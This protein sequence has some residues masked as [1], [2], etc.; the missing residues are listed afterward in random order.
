MKKEMCKRIAGLSRKLAFILAAAMLLPA[1]AT[2]CE[3][4]RQI[5]ERRARTDEITKQAESYMQKKYN[6]GFKVKK[7]EAAEGEQYEGDFFISFNNGVHAFYDSEDDLFYDDRQSEAINEAIMRDIWMPMFNSLG[8]VYENVND[9]SQTFNMVY[10]YERGGKDNKFSMYHENFKSAITYYCLHS[11]VSV[12]T[13]NLLLIVDNNDSYKKFFHTFKSTISLYFRNQTKGS[14]DVYSITNDLYY[15]SD[16]D[17]KE[18]DETVQGCLAHFHFGEEQYCSLTGFFEVTD[19]LYGTLCCNN[20]MSPYKGD[21]TLEPVEDVESVKKKILESM[22]NQEIGLIDKYT[23]KKRNI[24]FGDE[25]YTVNFSDKVKQ[26]YSDTVTVAFM[27]KDSNEPIAEYAKMDETTRS[28]FGYDM[29][30]TDFNATCLCSNNSRSTMFQ[31]KMDAEVYFW[32][33][34]Q[35]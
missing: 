31:F 13:D 21:L 26:Y 27:M 15:R 24:D 5:A 33:G 18:V 22:D 6:R 35:S 19:G 2:G 29:S 32:F 16:F 11:H 3:S 10:H 14:M 7:C 8:A 12:T 20:E 23:S 17:P 30:G 34:T 1:F 4:A 25:I 28:F 9:W